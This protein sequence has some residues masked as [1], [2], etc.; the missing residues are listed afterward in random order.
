MTFSFARWRRQTNAIG[1]LR[2]LAVWS[3]SLTGRSFNKCWNA[4]VS[5]IFVSFFG[6]SMGILSWLGKKKELISFLFPAIAN[7]YSCQSNEMENIPSHTWY[8]SSNNWVGEWIFLL[9]VCIFLSDTCKLICAHTVLLTPWELT[10]DHLY[11]QW[12]IDWLGLTDLID[13]WLNE[14]D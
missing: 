10:F 12:L 11:F 6:V 13:C 2:F 1:T 8:D 14:W 4:R 5:V 7:L 9:K 3:D